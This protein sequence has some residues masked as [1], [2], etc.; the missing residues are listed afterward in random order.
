MKQHLIVTV[1]AKDKPGIIETLAQVVSAHDGNWE[2]SRMVNLCGKFS[3]LLLV[4]VDDEHLEDLKADLTALSTKGIRTL[5]DVAD[6]DEAPQSYKEIR[7][8]LIGNDRPGIVKEVAQALSA[9]NI[10]VEELATDFSSMPW[11][12][13]PLFEA[14]GILQIPMD[15][16]VD[17]LAGSFTL[18]MW[19]NLADPI[20]T[21][22]ELQ[23]IP[24]LY[25]DIP[26]HSV[27][28][29]TWRANAGHFGHSIVDLAI[30]NLEPVTAEEI[31]QAAADQAGADHPMGWRYLPGISGFGTSVSEPTV[32]PSES[33]FTEVSVGHGT[34]DWSALT[35][36]QNPTQFHIVNALAD[37][38]VLEYRPAL[39]T[40]GSTNLV[41]AD[42]LPRAIR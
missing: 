16:D 12:G 19:E 17:E 36:E 9:R 13:E 40:K 30:K 35:W 5:I 29:G 10:N 27:V 18:V 11:S 37:L 1:I 28:G 7:F 26:D 32:F 3:G 38:P 23:G 22:R 41:L 31:E 2:E 34:I 21:G 8:N 33:T 6:V 15:S 14:N 24:K 20:L 4:T 42:R 39:V 25:A